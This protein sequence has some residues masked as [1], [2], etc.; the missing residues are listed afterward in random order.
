MRSLSEINVT[1][2]LVDLNADVNFTITLE[3]LD[4]YP[5]EINSQSTS[6]EDRTEMLHKAIYGM[7][8]STSLDIEDLNCEWIEEDEDEQR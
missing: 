4:V 6:Q 7:F 5:D 2:S 1:M 8:R 3:D